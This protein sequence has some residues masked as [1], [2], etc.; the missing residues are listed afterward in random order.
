MRPRPGVSDVVHEAVHHRN[1][2][3]GG[4][5]EPPFGKD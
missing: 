4:S 5:E 1:K 3:N 2:K